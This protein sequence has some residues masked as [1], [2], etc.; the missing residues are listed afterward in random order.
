MP[1]QIAP[2][3]FIPFVTLIKESDLTGPPVRLGKSSDA[4][5]AYWFNLLSPNPA[6]DNLAMFFALERAA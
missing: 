3:P 6:L 1:E 2:E 4:I 5:G